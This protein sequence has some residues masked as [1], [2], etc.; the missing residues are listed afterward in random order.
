MSEATHA[1]ILG[2]DETEIAI[3]RNCCQQLNLKIIAEITTKIKSS[4]DTFEIN[5]NLFI[6][7]IHQ[8]ARGNNLRKSLGINKIS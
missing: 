3:W 4:Y 5:N 6:T 7:T 1:I 8:L 2:G